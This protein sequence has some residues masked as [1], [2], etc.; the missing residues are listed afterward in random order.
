MNE[1]LFIVIFLSV[2]LL[3]FVSHQQRWPQNILL[4]GTQ[5]IRLQ[6]RHPS[7]GGCVLTLVP[8][9]PCCL[10]KD[11]FLTSRTVKCCLDTE[12]FEFPAYQWLM[13]M[14]KHYLKSGLCEKTQVMWWM[15][16]WSSH[17]DI[18]EQRIMNPSAFSVSLPPSSSTSLGKRSSSC[19]LRVK[20]ACSNKRSHDLGLLSTKPDTAVNQL[21]DI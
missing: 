14:P 3:M 11:T 15:Q 2:P 1:F 19:E 18:A 20:S 16:L 4:K 9:L 10:A 7:V 17:C 12:K 13:R 6:F 5:L 8:C 21:R